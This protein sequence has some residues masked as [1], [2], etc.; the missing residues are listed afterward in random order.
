MHY[1]YDLNTH[2][3]LIIHATDADRAMLAD[4][5]AHPEGGES[6]DGMLCRLEDDV[7]QSLTDGLT[8]LERIWPEEIAALTSAPIVG[9]RGE[10]EEVTAAWA[11]MDYQVRSFVSDL[12]ER[13]K[14]VFIS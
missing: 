3:C 10:G 9:F 1:T 5:L 6:E 2:G 8:E 4:R 11:Y 7:L 12:I 14:A 13:G